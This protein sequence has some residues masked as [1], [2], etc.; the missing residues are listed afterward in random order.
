[1]ETHNLH[2]FLFDGLPVRG[3]IVRLTESWREALRRRAVVGE[4]P[5]PVRSLVGQM[6]A[7]AVLM[8]SSIKFDGTLILQVHGDGPVKLAVAEVGADLRYRA[9]AKVVDE[10]PAPA[11]LQD[12]VNLHGQGRCAITLDPSRRTSGR[13]PYQGIV[14]LHDDQRAPLTAIAQAIE[15][16]MLQSEQLD[17]R[18]ILAANDRVAAGLLLQR[19]PSSGAGNLGGTSDEAQIGRNEDFNRIAHLASTVTRDELLDIDFDTLLRRLFWQENLQRFPPLT[20]D[21][22]CSCERRRVR[23]MLQGLGR[24]ELNSILAERDDVEV[25]CDFCGEQYRFDAVDVAAMFSAA[26][27]QALSSH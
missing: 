4:F 7:A 20:S 27:E 19:M 11:R 25:G 18:L 8:Q 14:P 9:T 21:F 16:Y 15:H 5:S 6:T 2:K 1:M 23:A 26:H 3:A 17:T 24:D 13:Q 22:H 10:I 12:M